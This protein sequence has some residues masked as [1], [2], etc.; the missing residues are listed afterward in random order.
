MSVHSEYKQKLVSPETAAAVVQSGDWV[1]YNFCLA[2][3]VALDKALA[4]R[5][6][7][8]A[9]I[10]VRGGMRMKP[11]RIID[12]DPQGEVFSY[13]S[14]HLTAFERK[15]CDAGRC[16]HTPMVY[17][18]KPLFYRKSLDVDVAMFSVS[19]MDDEGYFSFSLTNSASMAI[20]E[21]AGAVIL[22]V[23]E[24]LPA[25]GHG[26]EHK[27]HISE[28]THV[29]ESG[30]PD[31]PTIPPIPATATDE[32]IAALVMERIRDG[33]TVQL[34]I[35]ALPNAIGTMIVNSDLKNLGMH[36]E[37]LVDAY[38]HMA[39]AGKI[40]NTHKGIDRGKGV[41]S[42]CAG[43]QALYDW[44]R[45]N[46][47]LATG[48]VNYT[49]DPA[50]IAKN[51][52]M[53]TVNSCVEVDVLGQVTSETS[54]KRQISGTGGQLD[55]VNGGY[56]SPGG[57][58]F[59]CCSS[60]YTDKEGKAHSR[61]RLSLPEFSVVTDPRSEMHCIV[62]EWGIAD[63]AGRSIWERAERIINIA[64]PDFREE[65]FQGAEKLGFWKR[66]N[67]K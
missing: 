13:A 11:L 16:T 9:D 19:P 2:Q 4:A 6:D 60:T 22:E 65:L 28:V 53:V 61:V 27:I 46:D 38:M 47:M 12:V 29:V 39:Q 63:L 57:Q 62:T 64:H 42:F 36:T 49:N 14:W 7:E 66:S 21:R 43:S 24:N 56:L 54:G 32:T 40:T 26:Y 52:D 30:N 48:P 33:A 20:A 5:R 10:K 58:S 45:N 3:P 67:K 44:A 34:G 59:V 17:R 8:L 1:D 37:M 15:L 41:F 31:L 25:I 51:P 35:G 55:F 50:N 23:N 18:N